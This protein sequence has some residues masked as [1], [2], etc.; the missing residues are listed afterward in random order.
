MKLEASRK[1]TTVMTGIVRLAFVNALVAKPNPSGVL[2]YSVTALID[3]KDPMVPL[4][5]EAIKAAALEK[6]GSADKIPKG[7]R[8]PL[9]DGNEKEYAGFAGHLFLGCNSDNKPGIIDAAAKPINDEDRIYSGCWA[10]LDLNFFGYQKAGNVGV[11]AGLNNIQVLG[12]DERFS[13]RQA[14]ESVFGAVV[15]ADNP[16]E[17]K[18]GKAVDGDI[19]DMFA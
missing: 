3:P 14:A 5:K 9:R 12:D 17:G 7:L 8:N 16:F 15:S 13:G 11:A 2:K 6:W 18:P 1:A 10:R 4:L 19:D